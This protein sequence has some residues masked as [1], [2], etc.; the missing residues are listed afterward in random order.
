M[1]LPYDRSVNLLQRSV[2]TAIQTDL[3]F[4]EHV[5]PIR[6][7][8]VVVVVLAAVYERNDVRALLPLGLGMLFAAIADR[9]TTLQRRI[10]SMTGA[11]VAVTIGTAIGGLVSGNQIL[12]VV[13]AGVAGL[14]CGLAGAA[15]NPSMTAGVLG[16][17]VFT[18]FSGA[19]IDLL[20]WKNNAL[21]MLLGAA[22]MISTVVAEFAIRALFGRNATLRG[23]MAEEGYWTRARVHF[24]WS[25]Q[26]IL[27][28]IRL[29][30]VV[31]VATML[32]EILSF[33]HSYW[34]PMTVAWIARPDRDGTVEKVTLRVAGTLLGV[35]IAGLLIGVTAATSTES[36]IM[37]GVSAYFVLAFLAPN[38]AI[39]VAG[40]TAFVFFSFHLAGYPLDGAILSR[41]ASTLLAAALVFT[42]IH[43][44]PKSRSEP[45]SS[46]S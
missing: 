26:F 21:L 32:E 9:G 31:M 16:L 14:T 4:F 6:S 29:G 39:A 41:V 20:D 28:S 18:I 37:I 44:G 15:S 1:L 46:K 33:P 38:Y 22:I 27:H 12:H 23:E 13:I 34:I 5:R 36:L 10:S 2:R 8:L 35:A 25:D 40:I 19:P 17:V 30:I 45:Y 42:A 3:S 11:L 7:A 43:I 24:R